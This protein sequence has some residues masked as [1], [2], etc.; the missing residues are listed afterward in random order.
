MT[1]QIAFV[2]DVHGNLRALNGMLT[3]LDQYRL[4][5][6]VFL[7]DY[8]NKGPDSA[9]VLEFLLDRTMKE[10]FT[11]LRGNHETALLNAIDEND[12]AAFLKIGGAAT[13]RSYVAGQVGADV[14]CEFR[15]I[16]PTRHL[17][18]IRS[19][20]DRFETSELIAS[21]QPLVRTD[22][23]FAISAHVPVGERPV[24]RPKSASIDTGCGVKSGR[25]TALLWPSMTVAQV[26]ADGSTR[27]PTPTRRQ[28]TGLG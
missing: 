19:M 3:L 7:G 26:E 27:P 8:I 11:L 12:L 13:I 21:H 14:L 1:D 16:F 15:A 4:R 18:L 2:G 6:V 9:A 24:L 25:L 22:D 17:E 5:R 23:R 28:T 20:P 10:S